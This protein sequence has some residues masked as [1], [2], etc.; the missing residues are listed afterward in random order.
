MANIKYSE[1]LTEVLPS[2]AADPSDP[3]TENAIKRAV[4][5]FCSAAWVWKDLSDPID[6]TAGE[7]YYD[8]EPP[9]GSDIAVVMDVSYN[10]EPIEAKSLSWLDNNIPGWRTTTG[11]PKYYTQ[12]DL[13]QVILAPVP[14]DNL[15][16][17]LMV[18]LALQPSQNASSLPRWIANQH[19]YALAD[20][21]IARLMLMPNK[22][23]TDLANG[24]ARR[25]RFEAAIA[26]ARASASSALGRAA[27]RT[28]SQH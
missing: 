4:I 15:T 1:L 23:W 18:T 7:S 22:P 8:L 5:E 10:G 19:L 6:V 2:L 13:D 25:A 26:N 28:A 9:N 16:S 24:D 11:T 14:P 27:T 12:V 3:V 21:A 20:G 17:G